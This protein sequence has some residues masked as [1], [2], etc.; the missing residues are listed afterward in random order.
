MRTPIG[1]VGSLLLL[2]AACGSDTTTPVIA[3]SNGATAA[4][5]TATAGLGPVTAQRAVEVWGAPNRRRPVVRRA[6]AKRMTWASFKR[7][8]V[9]LIGG[10]EFQGRDPVPDG[11]A[12]FLTVVSGRSDESPRPL[13]WSA[14]LINE[15]DGSPIYQF[16]SFGPDQWPAFFDALPSE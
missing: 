2:L 16:G 6:D 13:E 3:G 4:P 5:M 9:P 10:A 1:V 14:Y 8:V 11:T 12:A 7:H 15:M